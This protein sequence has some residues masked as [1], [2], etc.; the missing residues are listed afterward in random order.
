MPSPPV[1]SM[2]RLNRALLARQ[3]LLRRRRISTLDAVE[4]LVGI[5][6]QSPRAAYVGLWTRV[7]GFRPEALERLMLE[8]S[9]VRVALMRSTIHLVS[10]RDCL[11]LREL[12]QPAIGRPSRHSAAR[13]AAGIDDDELAKAGRALLEAEPRTFKDLGALLK[14]RWPTCD[15]DALAMGV[16]ETVPLVQIPPRGLWHRGGVPSHAAAEAWLTDVRPARLSMSELVHRYLAAYGPASVLDAQTFTGVTGLRE[17]FDGLRPGL[18]T[19]HD[20]NRGELFDLANAPRPTGRA[21]APV[22]FL[23]EFDNILLSH[24]RRERILPEGTMSLLVLGNGLRPAFLVDGFVAGTWKLRTARRSTT[25]EVEPFAPLP[26]AARRELEDE[27][28]RLLAFAARGGERKT[29]SL[30]RS[31]RTGTSPP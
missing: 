7:A 22:R 16:R 28:R 17:V 10:A 29:V 30:V 13:R 2:L 9:V 23:P 3:L 15:A 21:R 20:E 27:G 12:V 5:Q 1:L 4:H 26:A 8:R 31:R 6:S 14:E 19:F 25:L 11:A 18:R 24:A